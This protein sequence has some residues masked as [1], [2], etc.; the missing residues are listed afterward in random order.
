M[1]KNFFDSPLSLKLWQFSLH[2]ERFFYEN[3]GNYSL[4][5]RLHPFSGQAFGKDWGKTHD[6]AGV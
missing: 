6:S 3:C 5:L 4:P 2:T 1:G